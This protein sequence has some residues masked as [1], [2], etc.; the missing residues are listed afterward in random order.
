M[1]SEPQ[2]FPSSHYLIARR[3][4]LKEQSHILTG[5]V[6]RALFFVSL[7]C[8][9]SMAARLEVNGK[10]LGGKTEGV[11]NIFVS[12]MKLAHSDKHCCA[13]AAPGGC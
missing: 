9:P 2:P 13:C 3:A 1:H 5:L 12:I 4:K 10:S 7:I 6:L 11:I 8:L